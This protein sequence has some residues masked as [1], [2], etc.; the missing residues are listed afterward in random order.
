M[1]QR[2]DVFQAIADP[3]RRDIIALLAKHP[4]NLN[5][6]AEQFDMSRQAVSLHVK[7]LQECGLLSILQEGRERHCHLQPKKLDE[8]TR[9]IEPLRKQFESRFEQLDQVLAKQKSKNKTP[10]K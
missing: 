1:E 9:W 4:Q 5:T 8:V 3:T 7:I 6:L 2:R 10:R